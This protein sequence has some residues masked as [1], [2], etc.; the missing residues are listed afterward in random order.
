MSDPF[1]IKPWDLDLIRLVQLGAKPA[2]TIAGVP[3]GTDPAPLFAPWRG[4][5]DYRLVSTHT[6]RKRTYHTYSLVRVGHPHAHKE[7]PEFWRGLGF[8]ACCERA[9]KSGK[10][11]GPYNWA[12]NPFWGEGRPFFVACEPFCEEATRVVTLWRSMLAQEVANG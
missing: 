8:P 2:V 6:V 1:T 5:L 7:R 4:G 10:S 11:N 9:F 12:Q 3:E